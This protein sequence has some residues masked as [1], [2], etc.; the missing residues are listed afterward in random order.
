MARE[1]GGQPLRRRRVRC[2]GW[3]EV[4][5]ASPRSWAVG[6]RGRSPRCGTLSRGGADG[7]RKLFPISFPF[8]PS[9]QCDFLGELF[10]EKGKL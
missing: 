9:S 7:S 10:E 5:L 1:R 3:G 8:P 2:A 4:D 6:P